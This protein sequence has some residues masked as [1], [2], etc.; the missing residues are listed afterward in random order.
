MLKGRFLMSNAKGTG[1]LLIFP[2]NRHGYQY[3]R[4]YDYYADVLKIPQRSHQKIREFGEAK[5]CQFFF[6]QT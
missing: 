4:K 2:P 3:I 1:I 5:S 6:I